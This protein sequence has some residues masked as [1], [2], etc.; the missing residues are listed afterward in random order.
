[1][2]EQDKDLDARLERIGLMTAGLG[3]SA[4][5][6][7]RVFAGLP[8]DP[9]HWGAGVMRFGRA[10][11]AVASLTAV[12]GIGLAVESDRSTDD[13]VAATY[14]LQDLDL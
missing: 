13:A 3:P 12:V 11:L 10:M 2:T 14:G 7:D 1:M 4:G 9:P 6:H 8:L 5:F